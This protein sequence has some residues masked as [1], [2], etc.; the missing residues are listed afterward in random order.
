M[1]IRLKRLVAH[2]PIYASYEA[3]T[4]PA[5]GLA[6]DIQY[7]IEIRNTTYATLDKDY[8]FHLKNISG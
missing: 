5:P 8:I 3:D 1:I 2:D 7:R 6:C 4:I